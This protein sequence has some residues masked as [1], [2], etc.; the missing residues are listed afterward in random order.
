MGRLKE[1]GGEMRENLVE[2]ENQE[3]KLTPGGDETS[4]M[5]DNQKKR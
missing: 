2:R 3:E 1:R 4:G 5:I